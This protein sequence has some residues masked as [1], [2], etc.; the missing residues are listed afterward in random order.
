MNCWPWSNCTKHWAGVGSSSRLVQAVQNCNAIVLISN[1]SKPRHP[2]TSRDTLLFDI[3]HAINGG[4]LRR[5]P[6]YVERPLFGGN[7]FARCRSFSRTW[8]ELDEAEPGRSRRTPHCPRG[9]LQ[10]HA[11]LPELPALACWTLVAG[12]LESISTFFSG[13]SGRCQ[14]IRASGASAR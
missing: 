12:I 3:L 7:K 9:K 6:W 10:I 1:F 2:F 5:Q 4:F 8:T 11:Q 13:A 14:T